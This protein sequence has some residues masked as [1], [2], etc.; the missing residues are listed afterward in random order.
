MF[1]KLKKKQI[2]CILKII[3]AKHFEHCNRQPF[4]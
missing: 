1:M 4:T 3:I 2:R